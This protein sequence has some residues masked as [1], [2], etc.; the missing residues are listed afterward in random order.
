MKEFEGKTIDDAVAKASLEL[1]VPVEKLKYEVISEVKGLFKKSAK[2]G[3][4]ETNDVI[5]FSKQYIGNLLTSIG[6]T[7]TYEATLKDDIIHFD[8]TSDVDAPKI[9]GRGG[10]TLKALNELVRS[11]I[12]N[13][14]GDH[15]RILLNINNYKD[16]KYE[17]IVAMAERIARSVEMTKITADLNPMTSDERRMIHNALANN[18]HIKT[19]SVGTGKDRHVTIQYVN[20]APVSSVAPVL[21]TAESTAEPL[22]DEKAEEIKPLEAK[23]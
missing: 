1:N 7:A 15:Y 19:I 12:F 3:V 18:T 20:I 8:M 6:L 10:E 11:A 14:Y 4:Y 17:K 23:E 2:I 13:K 22:K 16:Q 21:E 5:E 9:I